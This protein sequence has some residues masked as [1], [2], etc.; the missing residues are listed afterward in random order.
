M[1]RFSRIFP[2]AFAASTAACFSETESLC[3]ARRVTRSA[4]VSKV[5]AIWRSYPASESSAGNSGRSRTV[6]PVLGMIAWGGA[7]TRRNSTIRLQVG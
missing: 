3:M 5:I 2:A 1:I 7:L 6:R 4:P